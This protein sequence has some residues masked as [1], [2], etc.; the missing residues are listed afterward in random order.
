MPQL[1]VRFGGAH[2]RRGLLAGT[3]FASV[4]LR[5]DFTQFAYHGTVV[6]SW[7]QALLVAGVERQLR[8]TDL[9]ATV[10]TH[11]SHARE[12]LWE[13][14][15]RSRT[16]RTSELWSWSY[17]GGHY[18]IE[19]FGRSGADADESNAAQLWSTVFLGITSGTSLEN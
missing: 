14:I 13:A 9:P 6:W 15:E 11:L 3:R 12:H 5:R 19:P 18:R 16:L 4:D 1:C 17:A 8:R 7:Q 10:R 2:D